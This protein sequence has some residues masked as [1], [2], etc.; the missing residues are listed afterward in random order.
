MKK[1]V[2]MLWGVCIT[3][4]C[5]TQETNSLFPVSDVNYCHYWSYSGDG[6]G[7]HANHFASFEY[8]LSNT[9]YEKDGKTYQMV[10]S[11]G[12][13][14]EKCPFPI[15]HSRRDMIGIREEADHGDGSLII[16]STKKS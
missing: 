16:F 11:H 7:L 10:T 2:L 5:Y 8:K 12:D 1:V 15:D 6:S 14:M 13:R 9:F 4:S 3:L